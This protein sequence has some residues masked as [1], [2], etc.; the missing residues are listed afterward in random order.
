VACAARLQRVSYTR[1]SCRGCCIAEG[2]PGRAK[3]TDIASATISV[4]NQRLPS[5]R[6]SLPGG[7]GAA[8]VRSHHR[9]SMRDH[10]RGHTR[11]TRGA[12]VV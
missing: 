8:E 7:A 1:D 4:E 9:P 10:R 11:S 5:R 3:A 6:S 12:A 2:L